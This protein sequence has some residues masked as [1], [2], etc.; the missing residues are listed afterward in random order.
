MPDCEMDELAA[1]W[2]GPAVLLL[3]CPEGRSEEDGGGAKRARL[4]VGN[5]PRAEDDH[6]LT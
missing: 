4:S 1:E 6:Y 5:I 2:P 3:D